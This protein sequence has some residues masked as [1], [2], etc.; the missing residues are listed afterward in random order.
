MESSVYLDRILDTLSGS[1]DIYRPYRIGE[2]EYPAYAYFFSMNEK[3]VAVRKA[4]LWAVRTYEHILFIRADRCGA[5]TLA[6]AREVMES[7]MEPVLVR[8]GEKYPE[9]DHMVS[10]LTVVILSEHSPDA[11]TVGA[12]EKFRYEKNYL[13]TFRGHSEGHLICADLEREKVF[14]SRISGQMLNLYTKNFEL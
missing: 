5:D 11:D 12:V 6:Q 13:F 8:K 1:F 7:Y 9:Q 14:S 2:T 10:D 4:R 3:Y